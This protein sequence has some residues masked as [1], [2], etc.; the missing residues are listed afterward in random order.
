MPA[1]TSTTAARGSG[2]SKRRAPAAAKAR[3]SSA[4]RARSTSP[5]KGGATAAK[6]RTTASGKTAPPR[7]QFKEPAALK[8]LG[9]SLETA[10]AALMELRKSAGRDVSHAAKGLYTDLNRF[11]SSARR[12]SGKLSTALRRD[13]EQASRQLERS[14]RQLRRPAATAK[15][16]TTTKRKTAG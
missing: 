15:R 7:P 8:R 5:A 2:A 6:G 12:E 1:R 14:Q 9:R 4:S 3:A 16:K 10:D 11:L 13:F